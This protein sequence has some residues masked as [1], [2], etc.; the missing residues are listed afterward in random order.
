MACNNVLDE[1]NGNK[2]DVHHDL[3]TCI[4]PRDGS[5]L[6]YICMG[7]R[8]QFLLQKLCPSSVSLEVTVLPDQFADYRSSM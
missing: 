7:D 4:D 1:I 6:G 2:K 8:T 3:Y 5:S